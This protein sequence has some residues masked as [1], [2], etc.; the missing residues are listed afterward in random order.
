MKGARK[1]ERE[2]RKE[3]RRRGKGFGS[4]PHTWK[5]ALVMGMGAHRMEIPTRDLARSTLQRA[6]IKL[7][8]LWTGRVGRGFTLMPGPTPP[9]LSREGQPR[10]SWPLSRKLT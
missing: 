6:S 3:E 4:G 8:M 5:P 2:D 7:P 1:K 9:T 10:L